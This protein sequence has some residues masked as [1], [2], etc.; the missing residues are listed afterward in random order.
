MVAGRLA[1][2]IIY[3]DE[4]TLAFLDYTAATGGHTLVI[5]KVHAA[6]LWTVSEDA[7]AAVMRTVHRVAARQR[8][9]LDPEGLTL[10][11]ANGAAGWQDV[12]H[13]HVHVVPRGDGDGLRRPWTAVPRPLAELEPMRRRLGFG[14]TFGRS[15]GGP[16]AD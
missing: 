2:S 11:Q 8:E 1:T 5:P 15:I 9:V 12:F 4:H 14:R 10:F 7:A 6:D 13:L 16:N 3:E